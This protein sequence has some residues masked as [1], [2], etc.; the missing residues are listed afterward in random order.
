MKPDI[1]NAISTLA[2]NYGIEAAT[3][4]AEFE[5][6]NLHAVQSFLDE[7]KIECD[8]E[9]NRAIDVQLDDAYCAKCQAGWQSLVAQGSKVSESV[10]VIM[11]E[12]AEDVR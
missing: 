10:E 3:E 2:N 9:V 12:S 4:I 6:E 8:L 11:R 7:E 1:Y 5:V